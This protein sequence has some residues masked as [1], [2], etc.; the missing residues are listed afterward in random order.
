MGGEQKSNDLGMAEAMRTLASSIFERPLEIKI[1]TI[2]TDLVLNS[3]RFAT[4][5]EK[6]ITKA[7]QRQSYRDSGVT[8]DNKI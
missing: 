4:A 5:T 3:Q 7:Q 1:P 8:N 6:D 2:Q